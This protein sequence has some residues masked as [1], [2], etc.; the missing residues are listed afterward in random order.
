MGR[1]VLV[2]GTPLTEVPSFNYLGRMFLSSSNEWIILEKNVH[3]ARKKWERLAKILEREEENRRMVVRFFVVVVKAAI[4]FESK[5]WVLNLR[6]DKSLEGFHHWAVQQ[7]MI[8]GTKHQQ[9][10]TWV[11]I[12]IEEALAMVGL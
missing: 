2:Y 3:R 11:Y 8:M 1:F 6:L 7:M 5:K 10:E 4:L 9:D 12:T